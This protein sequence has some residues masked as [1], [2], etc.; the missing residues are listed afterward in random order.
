MEKKDL[1]NGMVVELIN[2][3]KLILLNSYLISYYDLINIE[4][5]KEDFTMDSLHDFDIIK[6]YKPEISNLKYMFEK[7][8]NSNLIWKR[9]EVD[10][11]KV[12]VDTKMQ[13]WDDE[14][15]KWK[16]CYFAGYLASIPHSWHGG[17]TSF[18]TT[19][20]HPCLKARLYKED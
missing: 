15:G 14:F 20:L 1:K 4:D 9:S 11:S 19:T 2:G 5:Y 7:C 12:E 16:N 18:T 6:I 13:E 3:Y 17:K 10:W 8:D